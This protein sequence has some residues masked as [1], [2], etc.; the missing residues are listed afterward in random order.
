MYVYCVRIVTCL[1]FFF[2]F[3]NLSPRFEEIWLRAFSLVDT[4]RDTLILLPRPQSSRRET[5]CRFGENRS[6]SRIVSSSRISKALQA[7]QNNWV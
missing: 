6:R 7:C 2:F 3:V 1:G 5:L 4:V